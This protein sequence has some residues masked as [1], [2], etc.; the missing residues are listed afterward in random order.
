[1]LILLD[2][3]IPRGLVFA[4][5]GHS[6]VESRERGWAELTNGDL[7]NAGERAGFHLLVTADQNIKYQQNLKGRTIALNV[8]SKGRW[9]LLRPMLPEIIAAVNAAT[10]G[11][12]AEVRIPYIL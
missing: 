4:L 11:S 6:V 1:M 2:T 10:P 5:A 9:S 8:L 7:L 3:N 12:Y